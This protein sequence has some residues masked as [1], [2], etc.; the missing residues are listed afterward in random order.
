[1]NHWL[2]LGEKEDGGMDG[3]YVE[4]DKKEMMMMRRRRHRRKTIYTFSIM[5]LVNHL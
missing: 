3:D 5:Y 2:G 4:K 1:M